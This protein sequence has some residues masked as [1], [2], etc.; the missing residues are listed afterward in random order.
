MGSW[1]RGPRRSG[2]GKDIRSVFDVASEM[3]EFSQRDG[4]RCSG[5]GEFTG[6]SGLEQKTVRP[7]QTSTWRSRSTVVQVK[8]TGVRLSPRV[9]GCEGQAKEVS[10]VEG[11][12][13]AGK[14]GSLLALP[15]TSCVS[16]VKLLDL[17]CPIVS[18]WGGVTGPPRGE[19][20]HPSQGESWSAPLSWRSV[21]LATSFTDQSAPVQ[22]INPY[23]TLL[24]GWP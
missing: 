20:E 8:V 11:V 7:A 13:R 16:S 21:Q 14:L 6:T 4:G 3:K 23:I 12:S 5:E 22:R 18:S 24:S 2:P 15:P 1:E 17:S 10:R 19:G 9:K